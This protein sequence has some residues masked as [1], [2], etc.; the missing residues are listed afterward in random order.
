M[1]DDGLSIGEVHLGGVGM[2]ANGGFGVLS[3]LEAVGSF[4][5]GRIAGPNGKA[6]GALAEDAGAIEEEFCAH[7]RKR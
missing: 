7:N 3:R 6:V 1:R 2:Q 4:F 5:N